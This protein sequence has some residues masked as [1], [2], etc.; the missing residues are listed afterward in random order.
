MIS[1]LQRHAEARPWLIDAGLVLWLTLCAAA[2][3]LTLLGRIPYGVHPDEAQVGTDVQKILNGDL[4]GVYTHAALGQPSA[5]AYLSTPAIW[6]MGDSALSVRITLALTGVAAVPLLYLLV[7]ITLGRLEAFLAAALLTV[8]YWHLL[9]SRVAHWSI[10]YG[11]VLLAVLV[12]VMLGMQR[13]QRAWFIAAGLLLGV[14]VYTYNIYPIVVIATFTFLAIIGVMK[15]RADDDARWWAGSS[16][17]LAGV[18]LVVA[19]PFLW[20]ISNPDAY[21][22]K[23]IDNYSEVG[24]ARSPEFEDASLGERVRLIAEQSWTFA[25]AYTYDAPLDNVDANGVRPVFDPVTLVLMA[26]GLVFAVRRLREPMIIAMLCC[27]VIIPL[28]ALLQRGSIMRQPVAA[29]PYAM[30][31]AALPLAALLREAW[32]RPETVRALAVGGVTAVV[33]LISVVT[34]RDCYWTWREH[35]WVRHIYYSQFTTASLYMRDLPP[36]TYVY[37]Y[38]ERASIDLETRAFLAPDV[39][40]EDRS[41]EFGQRNGS[42]ENVDRSRPAVFV[43]M[44]GYY[45][46]LPSLR[47]RYPDGYVRRVARDGKLEFI[48]YELP[49]EGVAVRTWP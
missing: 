39:E 18:A 13:R 49:A 19:L 16:L 15:M 31:L 3:R 6:I 47:E 27:L 34:V 10:S 20:Y 42:I 23:H 37:F 22:W 29:A 41:F 43:L 48:A 17:L 24:V 12:C 11:T 14:G 38:N 28:P 2:M 44:D 46:L 1:A 30:L 36:E 35:E 33:A 32:R 21:Y 5:H 7:R 4:L 45:G 26:C 40:G 9:Y 8:S 25:K